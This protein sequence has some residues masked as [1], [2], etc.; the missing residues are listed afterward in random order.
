MD[1]TSSLLTGGVTL[2]AAT[3]EPLVSWAFTG[4]H[5]PMPVSVPFVVASLAV[6]GL[7]ALY[8]VVSARLTK[9]AQPQQ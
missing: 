7:H 3:V 1:K 2:S 8:N 5:A 9:P 4:F 6:T